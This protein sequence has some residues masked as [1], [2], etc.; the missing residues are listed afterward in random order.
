MYNS[1]SLS[2]CPHIELIFSG[3][4]NVPPRYLIKSAQEKKEKRKTRRFSLAQFKE[5][6]TNLE[7]S[8]YVLFNDKK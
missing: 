2:L 5:V 6:E 7:C 3:T 4:F 1:S 8:V